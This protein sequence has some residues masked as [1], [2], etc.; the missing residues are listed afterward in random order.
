MPFL[1]NLNA[2]EAKMRWG[3]TLMDQNETNFLIGI[4]P[5]YEKDKEVFSKAF[6]QLSKTTFLP[7]RMYLVD[8]NGKDTQDYKFSK[9]EP[10]QPINPQFFQALAVKGWKVV[11]NPE[12][13]QA[14]EADP[15]RQ[16]AGR[17][18]VGA[19]PGPGPRPPR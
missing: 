5:R 9:V 4:V 10:N 2:R 16:P 19:R 6:L 13:V 8:T 3:M 18:Q 17:P 14:A 11:E 1:F 15:A 7:D 12:P